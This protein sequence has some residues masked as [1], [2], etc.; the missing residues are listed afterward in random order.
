MQSRLSKTLPLILEWMLPALPKRISGT[1]TRS[2][3][4]T[5]SP[6]Y[7]YPSYWSRIERDPD[8]P[9]FQGQRQYL[10]WYAPGIL[11]GVGIQT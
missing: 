7:L 10:V 8:H 5:V 1:G 4:S 9:A 2:T 3:V 11:S 6:E